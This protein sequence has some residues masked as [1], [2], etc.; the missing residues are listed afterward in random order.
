MFLMLSL[1]L[2]RAPTPEAQAGVCKPRFVNR[3]TPHDASH[4]TP[5]QKAFSWRLEKMYRDSQITG[6]R[7]TFPSPVKSGVS[8]ND[9]VWSEYYVPRTERNRTERRIPS[10]VVLH[11]LNDPNFTVTR[12]VATTLARRGIAALLLKLPYYGER[13]PADFSEGHFRDL[14]TWVGAWRQGVQDVRCALAWLKDRPETDA[15][16]LGVLGVSLGALVGSLVVATDANVKRAV[17]VVGGGD[18][19]EILW[20]APEA[21]ELR[22]KLLKQGISKE[23]VRSALK[24]IEPLR[25]ASLLPE[26]TVLMFNGR[27]DRTIPPPCARALAR[28]FGAARVIW[29]D[30]THTAMAV[31][32]GKILETTIL[33]FKGEPLNAKRLEAEKSQEDSE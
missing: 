5:P 25:F 16:R 7:L 20:S 12:M 22:A 24:P 14:A 19:A 33:F 23:K 11:F 31:H 10:V 4:L 30:E 18:L 2:L 26:G 32:L 15:D 13:R 6:Y 3:K 9:T 17:L 28:A 27:K 8:C 1:C 21:K 29:F